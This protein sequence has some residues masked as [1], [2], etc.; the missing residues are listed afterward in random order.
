[1]E[2]A[3]A[4]HDKNDVIRIRGEFVAEYDRHYTSRYEK[5]SLPDLY[6]TARNKLLNSIDTTLFPSPADRQRELVMSRAIIAKI[7]KPEL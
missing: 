2:Q 3:A 5:G 1:M 4:R 6:D 7:P